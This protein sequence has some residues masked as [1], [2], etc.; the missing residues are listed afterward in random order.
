MKILTVATL[1]LTFVLSTSVSANVIYQEDFTG[2]AVSLNGA[3]VTPSVSWVSASSF[4]RNGSFAAGSGTQGSSATLAFTPSQGTEYQLDATV[5]H[6]GSSG[7]IAMGFANGQSTSQSNLDRFL[8]GNVVGVAWSL[9]VA[10]GNGQAFLSNGPTP[11]DGDNNGGAWS[12][13][14]AAGDTSVDYRVYLDTTGGAGTWEATWY[15][16]LTTDLNFTEVR[17]TTQLASESINS[18]GFA[19]SGGSATGS[20]SNF[21][22]TEIPE[23][24]SLALLGLGSLMFVSRRRVGR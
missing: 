11:T 15:A 6:T 22:L 16:K 19:L 1:A 14:L 10:N 24:T 8:A 5:T 2:G 17:T 12:P 21:T 7:W 9:F 23:P 13:Q 3:A 4:S 18:V 20:I